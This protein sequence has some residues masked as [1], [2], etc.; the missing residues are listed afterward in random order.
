MKVLVSDYDGTLCIKHSVSK[1]NIEAIHKF[2]EAGNMFGIVTGRSM[3]SLMDEVHKYNISYDFIITNNGGVLFNKQLVNLSTKYIDKVKALEVIADIKQTSCVSYVVNDGYHRY[4]F[5]NNLN[6]VD[7]KY[8]NME[9][10]SEQ[11]VELLN[12]INIAQIVL[13]LEDDKLAHQIAD[14]LNKK[15]GDVIEAYVNIRCVDIV[16]K[17]ISKANGVK[18]MCAH[19]S[20]IEEHVFAIGDSYNDVSMI[21]TFHGYTLEHANE[22]IKM[23]AEYIFDSVASCISY[24]MK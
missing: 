5:I 24:L 7:Y 18:E 14:T 2:Q 15:Y 1:E 16:P 21:E 10:N 20:L 23:K 19:L 11:E 6:G 8:A 17:G 9:D 4:K 12:K 13:S 22:D 3:E